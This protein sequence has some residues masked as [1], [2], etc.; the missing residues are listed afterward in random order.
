MLAFRQSTNYKLA[1]AG[2]KNAGLNPWTG[3]PV[4]QNSVQLL[5]FPDPEL[6]Q[7]KLKNNGRAQLL[8]VDMAEE[9]IFKMGNVKSEVLLSIDGDEIKFKRP[10]NFRGKLIEAS[11]INPADA[12]AHHIF[13]LEY[14]TEFNRI[15]IA[16]RFGSWWETASHAR[17][18][19]Q[20]NQDW[21]RF[22]RMYPNAD[23]SMA[24]RNALQLKSL[25]GY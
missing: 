22:F 1:P 25:Y 10:G 4:P 12:R 20:Y 21:G 13:P 15:G 5:S 18:A 9:G 16:N 8:D 6:P 24:I 17:N 14:A 7:I 19:Y 3:R 2:A 23:A 11:G